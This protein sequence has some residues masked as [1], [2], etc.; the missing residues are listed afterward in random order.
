M[1]PFYIAISRLVMRLADCHAAQSR[2]DAEFALLGGPCC[3]PEQHQ[4]GGAGCQN[5]EGVSYGFYQNRL[6]HAARPHASEWLPLQRPHGAVRR[7]RRR[8]A[9][10]RW[11]HRLVHRQVQLRQPRSRASA[12]L[13][14][15]ARSRCPSARLAA[16]AWR[17]TTA[18]CS[19]ARRRTA[20]CWRAATCAMRAAPRAS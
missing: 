1:S 8:H 19:T 3:T 9:F 13:T 15:P 7:R 17:Q 11:L 5:N 12:P 16:S 14:P 18:A 4:Y 6:T 2:A 20:A 10:R